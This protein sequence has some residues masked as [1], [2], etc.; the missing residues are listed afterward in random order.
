[1]ALEILLIGEHRDG[2][3]ARRLVLLRDGHRVEIRRDHARARAGLLHL[4]D[5]A[6]R[7]GPA[8]ERGGEGP[9]IVAL[10][11]RRAQKLQARQQFR[12]LGLFRLEDFLQAIHGR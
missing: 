8:L 4:G 5:Q 9:E 6:Q 1:M 3:R 11:G 7:L 10:Q 2:V 12:D